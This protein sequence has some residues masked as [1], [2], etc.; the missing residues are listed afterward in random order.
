MVEEVALGTGER[1]VNDAS[2]VF[3]RHGYR[4][5]IRRLAS[6]LGVTTGAIYH[7]F[8]SKEGLFLEVLRSTV[9][10]DT[11][12]FPTLP[13]DVGVRERIRMLLVYVE[14]READLTRRFLVLHEYLRRRDTDGL[15]DELVA[16]LNDYAAAVS[17][18]L[19]SD[20]VEVG[21]FVLSLVNGV[22]WRRH[23]DG[24]HTRWDRM[25]PMLEQSVVALLGR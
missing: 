11:S 8:G 14:A 18:Y 17:R 24:G 10:A 4:V 22:L 7:H 23:L 20:D 25:G 2:A 12:E 19:G 5:P 1:L 16:G 3:A 21:R 15:P 13:N 6:E 9:Q